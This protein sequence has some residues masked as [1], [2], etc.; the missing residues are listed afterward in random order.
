V[1]DEEVIP[2]PFPGSKYVFDVGDEIYTHS[3]W[4]SGLNVHHIYFV[5]RQNDAE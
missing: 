4:D 3:V 1:P 2:C 5:V